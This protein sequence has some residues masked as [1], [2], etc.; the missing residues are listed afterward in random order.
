MFDA[1]LI[2]EVQRQPIRMRSATR[3]LPISSMAAPTSEPFKSFLGMPM[4]RPPSGTRTSAKSGSPRRIAN[5]IH[6]HDTSA[7]TPGRTTPRSRRCCHRARRAMESLE[8]QAGVVGTRPSHRAL[9]TAGQVR[10]WSCWFGPSRS[11]DPADL[12]GYGVFGLIDA[13]EKFD[14][15]HGVKFETYAAPRIRGAIYD[16]FANSTGFRERSAPE[17]AAS[18][19]R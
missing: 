18:N 14:P 13:I 15:S 1:F 2:A 17:V 4:L 19:R 16:G 8:S 3:L 9:F 12:V 10:R 7:S 11:V 6:E 5:R